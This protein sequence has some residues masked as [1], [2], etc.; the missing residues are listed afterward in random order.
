[1]NQRTMGEKVFAVFNIMIMLFIIVIM[2]YPYLNVLIKAFDSEYN[3]GLVLL[4]KKFTLNNFATLL[5]DDTI[6]T[7]FFVSVMRVLIAVV[8]GVTVQ[9]AAAYAITQ[10]D[11]PGLKFFLALFMIPMFI[12]AGQIPMYVTLSQYGLLNSFWV[13]IFPYLFSFYNVSI[14][15]TFIKTTIPTALQEAAT[16]DGANEVQ[17]FYK[18][19]I[20][21]CKPI[22]ATIALWIMVE[23]W[24]GYT[25]NL[26]YVRDSSL[27]TLQYKMMQLI[28]E[29]DML[30]KLAS[31]A[32]QLG[33]SVD[34]TDIP[35]SDNL[36]SA[37]VIIS[38]VP[39]IC[40]YPFLQKYFVKGIVAGSVK[41]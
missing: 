18:I 31:Q 30:Q 37:Q 2:L 27:F 20:P 38:T 22:L 9:F 26:L 24:N 4:P 28:K 3:T 7:S 11:L 17:I 15:R 39:I 41:E 23:H 32:A 35:K 5:R 21:L 36:V 14:I 33:I 1:M 6:I 25:A 19:I 40:V 16:I 8:L 13:Y 12:S 34:K 29:S 10:Q